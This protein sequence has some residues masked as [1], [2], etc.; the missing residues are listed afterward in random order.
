MRKSSRLVCAG[1]AVI[2]P[3][4]ASHAQGGEEAQRRSLS[5]RPTL[6][7]IYDS[8]VYKVS[9]RA[10]FAAGPLVDDL[11]VS[12]GVNLDIS[13]PLGRQRVFLAGF[14]GYDFYVSNSRLDRERIGLNGGAD[15]RPFGTCVTTLLVDYGRA[16]G[17]LANGLSL[18]AVP[19]TEE[20]VTL[21]A[22]ARCGGAIGLQPGI[23]YRHQRVSNSNRTFL[24]NNSTSDTYSASLAYVRPS[25]GSL[26]LYGNYSRGRFDDRVPIA[27]GIPPTLREGIDSYGAGLRYEREIG[28]RLRGWISGG[29]TWVN[30]NT[31]GEKFRGASYAAAID[32]RASE[33][34]AVSLNASRTAELPNLI[35]V[36]YA[37]N[38]SVSLSGS[39]RLNPR[40][41]LNAGVN[42]QNRRLRASQ[43][44]VGVPFVATKDE[45][46]Q[47]STGAG[48][49]LGRRLRLNLGFTH[50]QRRSDNDFFRYNANTVQLG[51]SYEL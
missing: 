42:Y 34:L 6:Q 18:F 9:R 17:D 2:A 27:P 45:L 50:Q 16:Q 11:S 8:N 13:L 22:D 39:Y 29:Y 35:N 43:A 28:A 38:D 21:G 19:N 7:L 31:G 49:D 33:R 20:R 10:S 14:A 36:L 51:A 40:I 24:T 5:I 15:L 44:L 12:P 4:T 23:G 25:F 48:Y 47:L 46:L 37:I 30:P 26:S 1:L 41:S 3:A 32:Y